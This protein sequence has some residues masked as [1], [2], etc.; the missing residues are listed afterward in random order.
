MNNFKSIKIILPSAI[1]FL[2]M[3]FYAPKA[4][5]NE[6]MPELVLC[7]YADSEGGEG[8]WRCSI[9]GT[10]E[11]IEDRSSRTDVTRSCLINPGQQNL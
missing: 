9:G 5:A 1:L 6:R 4:I 8:Y 7:Y 11:W 3:G 10:C 2:I